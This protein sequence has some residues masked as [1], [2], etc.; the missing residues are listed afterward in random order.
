M[1]EESTN[2]DRKNYDQQQPQLQQSTE[3]SPQDQKTRQESEMTA[4]IVTAHIPILETTFEEHA[5]Y[6]K[7][8]TSLPSSMMKNQY[9]MD[10][11]RNKLTR[12]N[13][14]Q[15]KFLF[16]LTTLISLISLGV[17]IGNYV[18]IGLKIKSSQ[19]ALNYLQGMHFREF[20]TDLVFKRLRDM[21]EAY[22]INDTVTFASIRDD[23]LRDGNDTRTQNDY[24]Y[25]ERT[26]RLDEYYS[27]TWIPVNISL[28]PLAGKIT[29]FYT[30]YRITEAFINSGMNAANVP[31]E[32]WNDI[33]H[34]NY[35]RFV[36]D[37]YAH[38]PQ[39]VYKYAMKSIFFKDVILDN[40]ASVTL[41]SGLTVAH[42]LI[43]I[44]CMMFV[45]FAI[46]YL[47][48]RQTE[49]LDIFKAIKKS[50]V[51]EMLHRIETIV[52]NDESDGIVSMKK[53]EGKSNSS[54]QHWMM[55]ASI[56]YLI[57][58]AAASM[59]SIFLATSNIGKI[60]NIG[61]RFTILDECGGMK[62]QNT[63]VYSAVRE[64]LNFERNAMTWNNDRD[65]LVAH[66]LDEID[67]T[68]KIFET[69]LYGNS[70]IN[71]PAPSFD[72]F[73]PSVHDLFV[74]QTCV[75]MNKTFCDTRIYNV[76]IGYTPEVLNYGLVR[77][78]TNVLDVEKEF[79]LQLDNDNRTFSPNELKLEFLRVSFKDVIEGYTKCEEAL[80]L[81]TKEL[82]QSYVDDNEKLFIGE[83]AVLIIGVIFVLYR[84]IGQLQHLDKCIANILIHLPHYIRNSSEVAVKVEALSKNDDQNFGFLSQLMKKNSKVK[85][86][87]DLG[88]QMNSKKAGNEKEE[89]LEKQDGNKVILHSVQFLEAHTLVDGIYNV[90]NLVSNVVEIPYREM[91]INVFMNYYI[92]S[93]FS[94]ALLIVNLGYIL[95]GYLVVRST[96]LHLDD[97]SFAGNESFDPNISLPMSS[98][99]CL[100]Y[101]RLVFFCISII[102]IGLFIPVSVILTGAFFDMNPTGK[103]PLN[104]VNGRVSLYYALLKTAVMITI[105]LLPESFRNVK[106]IASTLVAL[107]MSFL[108]IFYQPYYNPRINQ[109]RAG[110]YFGCTTVGITACLMLIIPATELGYIPFIVMASLFLPGCLIG[111]G[112]TA[113]IA[114]RTEVL[115]RKIEQKLMNSDSE[116]NI[117]EE[118]FVFKYP[119]QVEM[120]ARFI[121]KKMGGR[122][123]K[124]NKQE[125]PE[126]RR[127]FK[128]G[129]QEFP[130]NAMIR[131]SYAA[132]LFYLTKEKTETIKIILK[133]SSLN[134]SL[135]VSFLISTMNRVANQS[136]QSAQLG[137][138][139]N[140]DISSFSEYRK[141]AES[142]QENFSNAIAV[143]LEFWKHLHSQ[144]YKLEE[145][146]LISKL[147]YKFT[148]KADQD[149]NLLVTRFP[150][151]KVLL[152]LY[153]RFCF[154]VVNDSNKGQFYLDQ[155]DMIE[156]NTLKR[157]KSLLRSSRQPSNCEVPG[158]TETLEF[159]TLDRR[160]D[161]SQRDHSEVTTIPAKSRMH[162]EAQGSNL[163]EEPDMLDFLEFDDEH[164]RDQ[165]R[166]QGSLPVSDTKSQHQ[167]E[168]MRN[169]LIY[170]NQ[171]QFKFLYNLTI[172]T[173]LITLAIIIGNYV[174]IG[175]ILISS[176]EALTYL[177]GMH[178]Q[179]FQSSFTFK[180][181]R[182][183]QEYFSMND[184]QSFQS[185]KD[186]IIRDGNETR[187][188]NDFLYTERNPKLD[189]F[190]SNTWIPVNIS[191]YPQTQ[192]VTQY[193]TF[194]KITEGF[195]NNGM[196]AANV[197]FENWNNITI[198]NHFRFIADNYVHLSDSVYKKA[199]RIF[200]GDITQE[201]TA[202][203]NLMAGLTF[204]HI[205]IQQENLRIFK[206]IKHSDVTEMLNR[207]EAIVENDES[208]GIV[209]TRK[210]NVHTDSLQKHWLTLTLFEYVIYCGVSMLLSILLA[211]NIISRFYDM[212]ER[213]NILDQCGGMKSQNS[214][215]YS[216]VRDFVDFPSNAL[217]WNNDRDYLVSHYLSEVI[218]HANLFNDILYGNNDVYPP[219][220]SYD[221]YPPSVHNLFLNRT[222]ISS[223][224]TLCNSRVY[225]YKIGYTPQVLNH[226][227]VRFTANILDVQTE[228]YLQLE[229]NNKTFFPD[230]YK[231]EF[232]KRSFN[233]FV[234]GYTTCEEALYLKTKSL[235]QSYT[236][237]TNNFL[238]GELVILFI[239]AF[240]ILFRTIYDMQVCF[241]TEFGQL[242]VD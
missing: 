199:I 156:D 47:R 120:T 77:F 80:Y 17:L 73:P 192:K 242:D 83:I 211:L 222:C 169:V 100:E 21:Q 124:F 200:L 213:F 161:V 139:G 55:L 63:R 127:I 122:K 198:N 88:A 97:E 44:I 20:Q 106:I 58:G 116:E 41:I 162:S 93:S 143:N 45:F 218:H 126:L 117:S 206:A 227:L 24:L 187:I 71:P 39:A 152:R 109:L 112:I 6:N 62:S 193:Y 236:E 166:S 232:L 149:F 150:N 209:S 184:I 194:Y 190:Y 74:N 60:Y 141:I 129:I 221:K 170:R 50:D 28:F 216:A 54:Q 233:D 235:L 197:P 85:L 223:N 92:V 241:F 68:N 231:L 188:Q 31:Y 94:V 148:K 228:F 48:K 108:M 151:S 4:H 7:S 78:T 56:E 158:T 179:E 128:R 160:K 207:T 154:E 10:V 167:I 224:T 66:Y 57:Y 142:A 215:V 210:M 19:T 138:E 18:I 208:C 135:D 225:D 165:L 219:S 27:S 61:Q 33:A 157:K 229:L 144:N 76:T 212:G 43:V 3:D 185:V 2:H 205:V 180:R 15:I 131:L 134:P 146:E 121:A 29:Q 114:Q 38:V 173:Y 101:P 237:E 147:L 226:G 23:I 203:T 119:H 9:G 189:Q 82:L 137:F 32:D 118:V 113:T 49:S 53:L 145:I 230:P 42:L 64:F 12:R 177:R 172:V 163:E 110:V 95:W 36:A 133:A 102:L 84:T 140:L 75:S 67:Y 8:Q 86:E 186:E 104:R 240:L 196:N 65:Y 234:A 14:N 238:V 132:Y 123:I 96:C 40:E 87:T 171:A 46:R 89:K 195:V 34:N 22:L 111:A 35:F 217:T 115:C 70:D 99:K 79:D 153:A 191:I 182:D 5:E 214:R 136:E 168:G 239:G 220:P 26:P 125:L 1:I 183:M 155:A 107:I 204:A 81:K 11:V 91:T 90:P 174:I 176:N 159:N 181:L 202:N 13:W 98:Y 25:S 103:T 59:L 105:H 51:T 164:D 178:F 69:I 30:F 72:K 52:E 175:T 201:N 130:D 37:N 16:N